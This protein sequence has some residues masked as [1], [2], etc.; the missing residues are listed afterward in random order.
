MTHNPIDTKELGNF[1]NEANKSTYANKHAAKATSSRLGSQDY[2][3][4]RGDL[5]Y[6][7]TYFGGGNFIGEEIIYKNQKPVWGANYFG[8]LVDTATVDEKTVY[9]FLRTALMQEYDD[10]IPVR[11]PSNFVDNIWHY[12]FSVDGDLENF[13]GQEE[14]LLNEKVVYRCLIHGGCIK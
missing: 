5:S 13:V 12:R 7:D 8:Y 1:L 11:G 2:H 10:I 4:E 14:I 6:H 3:F 9:E